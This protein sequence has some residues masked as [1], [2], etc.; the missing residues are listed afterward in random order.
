MGHDNRTGWD[1]DHDSITE[2]FEWS[3]HNVHQAFTG[4]DPV[5]DLTGALMARQREREE[6]IEREYQAEVRRAVREAH[7]FEAFAADPTDADDAAAWNV[8]IGLDDDGYPPGDPGV[9]I[10][11]GPL[12][13]PDYE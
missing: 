1:H 4:P 3:K 13:W 9:T 8:D 12:D 5:H 7:E 2:F 10:V 6:R 11:D